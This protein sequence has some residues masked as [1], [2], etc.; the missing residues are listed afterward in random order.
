MVKHDF[1]QGNREPSLET[2]DPCVGRRETVDACVETRET[3]DACVGMRVKVGVCV[4]N[5]FPWPLSCLA[6]LGKAVPRVDLPR[7]LPH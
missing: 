4:G 2:T 1:S 3:V 7:C 6:A 5:F